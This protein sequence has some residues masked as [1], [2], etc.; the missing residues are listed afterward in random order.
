[1]K[2]SEILHL[3]KKSQMGMAIFEWVIPASTVVTVRD[4]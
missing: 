2:K 3:G 4:N 1:M